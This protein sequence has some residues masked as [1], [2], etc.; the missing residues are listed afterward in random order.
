MWDLSLETANRLYTLSWGGLI[1]AALLVLACTPIQWWSGSVKERYA[2]DVQNK[3][4]A[5]T[6]RANERVEEL[7]NQNLTLETNLEKERAERLRLEAKIAPRRIAQAQQN[8]L[9]AILKAAKLPTQHGVIFGSPSTQE[10][11]SLA[12][13]LAAP[14]RGAG[15]DIKPINGTPT[16]TIL[17]PGGV[18]VQFA[19]LKN[20]VN[21]MKDDSAAADKLVEYLNSIEIEATAISAVP[22][23]TIDKDH[24]MRIVISEKP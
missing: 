17:H 24:T 13:T 8:E 10:S 3:L 9:T 11:E 18:V 22:G 2:D 16:A 20:N 19:T 15:W 14:L 21:D 7:R 5:D 23:L 6:A 12:R 4:N 1:F